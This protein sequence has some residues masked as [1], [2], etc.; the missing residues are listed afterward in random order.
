MHEQVIVE[1]NVVFGEAERELLT[2]D[3]YHLAAHTTEAVPIVVLIHGGAY[4]TGSKEMYREWGEALA[5]EGY[6]AMAINYRLAK[7]GYASYPGV[8]QDIEEAL[9]WLVANANTRR[10]DVNRIGLIGDSAGAHLAAL[11]ALGRR[12]FSYK[13]CGVVAVY[14]IFDLVEEWLNPVSDRAHGMFELFLGCPLSGHEALYREASPTSH[15]PDAVASATFDTH[16]FLTWGAR[17]TVVNPD[18]SRSFRTQLEQAGI[19]VHCEEIEDVGHFWFNLLPGIAGGGVNDY[20]NRAIYASLVDFLQRSVRDSI[21]MNYSAQR[22]RT[23][24]AIEDLSPNRR[25]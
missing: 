17:D 3:L 1:K 21:S 22:L 15:I 13:V 19:A 2:A 11:F 8:M 23:L 16:F 12:P 14:G 24:A 25:T 7:P 5:R 10:I 18:Q 4:Q 9:T 20:P 6:F